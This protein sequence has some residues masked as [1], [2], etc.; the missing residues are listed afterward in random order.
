MADIRT[1]LEGVV[2]A[3][4]R[5]SKVVGDVGELIYAGYDIHDVAEHA[6]FEEVAYLFWYCCLP[7]QRQLASFKDNLEIRRDIP[8][9]VMD[10]IRATPTLQSHPMSVLRT[11]VSALALGDP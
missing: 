6:S 1:G 5:M 10:L 7:N 4:S 2:V 9:H 3:Q 8:F 11:A